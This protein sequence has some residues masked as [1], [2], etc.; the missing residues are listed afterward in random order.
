MQE[1]VRQKLET[2]VMRLEQQIRAFKELH[3]SELGQILDELASLRAD[4]AAMAGPPSDSPGTQGT[5]SDPAAA[6]PKRA[7][8]LAEQERK[9]QERKAPKSRRELLRGRDDEGKS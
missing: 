6:S 3:A 2:R 5:L 9:E 7:A 8:W 4:L 1:S